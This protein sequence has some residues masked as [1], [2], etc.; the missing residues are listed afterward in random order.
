[1]NSTSMSQKDKKA[2]AGVLMIVF[3]VVLPILAAILGN[4]QCGMGIF[5]AFWAGA[6]AVHLP[7]WKQK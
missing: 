7:E 4:W 6:M 5:V 1:M 2:I 3:L